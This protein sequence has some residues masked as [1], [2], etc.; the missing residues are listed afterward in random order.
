M[1]ASTVEVAPVNADSAASLN[2]PFQKVADAITQKMV[3][4]AA[5]TPDAA[6]FGETGLPAGTFAAG[7]TGGLPIFA[8]TS[9]EV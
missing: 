8:N 2:V 3:A 5:P 1:N 7:L 9:L 4:S 6:T